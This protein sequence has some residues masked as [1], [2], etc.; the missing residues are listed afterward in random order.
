MHQRVLCNDQC[1]PSYQQSISPLSPRSDVAITPDW[2]GWPCY[3]DRDHS[4]G[5]ARKASSPL[6]SLAQARCTHDHWF[7]HGPCPV[8][9]LP[10]NILP[11]VEVRSKFPLGGRSH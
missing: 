2:S 11:L 1:L 10:I 3:E 9:V 8:S 5:H 6:L 4:A 7:R